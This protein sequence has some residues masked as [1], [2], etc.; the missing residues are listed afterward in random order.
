MLKHFL[1][2]YIAADGCTHQG[3]KISI[4]TISLNLAF[5]IT[6]I[7][8]KVKNQ[9]STLIM[10]QRLPS[11]FRN[12]VYIRKPSYAVTI[13]SSKKNK[14]FYTTETGS[15]SHIYTC[16]NLKYSEEGKIITFDKKNKNGTVKNKRSWEKKFETDYNSKILPK[17]YDV[18]TTDGTAFVAENV[19]VF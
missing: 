2:G 18:K 17:F 10:S 3:K 19:L 5:G 12:T 11:T 14:S 6:S 15:W 9:P 1:D 7:I 8:A 13:Y 16:E 4:A